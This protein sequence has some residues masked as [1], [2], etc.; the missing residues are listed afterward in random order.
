M[1]IPKSS[2]EWRVAEA[3][4]KLS[5]VLDRAL[6]GEPQRIVRR[7]RSVVVIDEGVLKRHEEPQT[8]FIEHLLSIPKMDDDFEI[9]ARGDYPRDPF[10]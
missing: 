1:L 9:P 8:T 5:E 7:G 4:N 10:K 6:A 2:Q 3:K